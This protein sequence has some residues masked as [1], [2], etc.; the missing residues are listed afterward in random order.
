MYRG[1]SRHCAEYMAASKSPGPLV[2]GKRP[3][4]KPFFFVRCRVVTPI[5]G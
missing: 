4:I 2:T 3:E 1:I 5:P